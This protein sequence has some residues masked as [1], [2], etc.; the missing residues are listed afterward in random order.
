MKGDTIT[1]GSASYIDIVFKA[2]LLLQLF[3]TT[4]NHINTASTDCATVNQFIQP[5]SIHWIVIS[6][7]YVELQ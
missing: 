1:L 2:P 3:E 7:S 6:K 5:L 4:I